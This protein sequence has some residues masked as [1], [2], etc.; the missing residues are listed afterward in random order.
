MP[1]IVFWHCPNDRSSRR[2]SGYLAGAA[3]VMV[4]HN[5]EFFALELKTDKET[6]SEEQ[7]TFIDR[8]NAADG[9][10]F[11]AKGLDKALA[12]L[13]AWNLIRKEAA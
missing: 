3:D 6:A 13:E 9:F 10:A 5:G 12:C 7:L 1:G 11:C 4:L 2:K 8:I